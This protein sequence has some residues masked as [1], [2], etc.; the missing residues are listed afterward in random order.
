MA[1]DIVNGG[2]QRIGKERHLQGISAAFNL[3]G[4]GDTAR[5]EKTGRRGH[6]VRTRGME[7]DSHQRDGLKGAGRELF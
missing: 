5:G 2:R 3:L 1:F 7:T 4:A 6:S